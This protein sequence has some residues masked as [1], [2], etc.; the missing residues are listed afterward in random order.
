MWKQGWDIKYKDDQW[1]S[2]PLQVYH[3]IWNEIQF[4]AKLKYV[5]Q[6]GKFSLFCFYFRTG[7]YILLWNNSPP[8]SPENSFFPPL[9]VPFFLFDWFT[10]ITAQTSSLRL[11]VQRVLC[12]PERILFG[13]L[14]LNWA[15]WCLKWDEKPLNTVILTWN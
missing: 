9:L 13:N 4:H 14:T 12:P 8:P 6:W 10:R 1:A 15:I 5:Y 3:I 11:G 2:D 7:V